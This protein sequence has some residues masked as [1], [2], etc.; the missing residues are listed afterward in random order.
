MRDG[1]ELVIETPRLLLPLLKPAPLK[2]IHGGR[3]SGKSHFFAELLVEDCLVEPTRAVCLREVQ[4]SLSQSSKLL[5]EDKIAK[6]GL[7]GSFRSLDTKI[8][9]P[10]GGVINFMGLSDQTEDSIKSIEGYKRAWL[11]EAQSI[12]Q[13]SLDLLLPTIR[14]DGSEVWASWNPKRPTDPID[15]L[16][17]GP[18]RY[19]GTIAIEMNYMHNPRFPKRLRELMEWD[20]RRDPDKYAHIWLGKYRKMS[21]TRV[22]KNWRIE[23]VTPPKGVSFLFGADWGFSS[24]PTVIICG[25][26]VGKTLYIYRARSQVGVEI[27]DTP[28]FFDHLDP[29]NVGFARKW[30][31]TADSARPETISHMK[32]HGYPLIQPSRKGQGSV[33]EGISFLKDYDIV[34]DPSCTCVIDEFSEFSYKL[35]KLTNLPTP[36]LEDKKNHTIDAA[37]YMVEDVRKPKAGVF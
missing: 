11:E 1:G 34:V 29:K 21:Q 32:K 12:S 36:N 6:F 23:V 30:V 28:K 37:R 2:G 27:S 18:N 7:E 16:M 31:I 17:R 25:F 19:P 4:K 22:F 5:I 10:M 9:A 33:E 20:K 3:G 13:N 15:V 14:A 35:D 26:I 8:I 24:D